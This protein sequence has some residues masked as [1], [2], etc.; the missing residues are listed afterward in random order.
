MKSL[1]KYILEYK[2]H[3]LDKRLMIDNRLISP[4]I[5][6]KD[7]ENCAYGGSFLDDAS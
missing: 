6:L 2:Q 1:N 7:L 3:S 5:T 4:N